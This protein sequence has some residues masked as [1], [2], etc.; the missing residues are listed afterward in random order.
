[1]QHCKEVQKCTEKDESHA[2][3]INHV[4]PNSSSN[5]LHEI[6]HQ[7]YFT[8]GC[9]FESLIHQKHF[10]SE[11][12]IQFGIQLSHSYCLC[13]ALH[14]C[15][16]AMTGSG[17]NCSYD[18][19]GCHAEGW[20]SQGMHTALLIENNELLPEVCHYLSDFKP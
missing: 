15:R 2:S 5:V 11:F 8:F 13:S 6:L 19:A 16:A 17:M 1:M 18:Y 20:C 12:C 9:F 14:H 3:K 7:V 4:A 10:M